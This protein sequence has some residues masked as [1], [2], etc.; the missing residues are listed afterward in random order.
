MG[1]DLL[2]TLGKTF[3]TYLVLKVDANCSSAIRAGVPTYIMR[4]FE[5]QKYL[6]YNLKY[7]V[8][9]CIIVPPIVVALINSPLLDDPKYLS[10][11][12]FGFCGAAPLEKST[13]ARLRSK[14]PAGVPLTQA[15]GM[16]EISS[17]GFMTQYPEDDDT[18]SIGKLIP[19][20]EA[21]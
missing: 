12:K 20:L 2:L 17:I 7:Q 18:G 14:L 16:T 6:E 3:L 11:V 19:G 9:E 15:F 8:T 5:L 1:P 10:N 4:R 13:Q 21:K